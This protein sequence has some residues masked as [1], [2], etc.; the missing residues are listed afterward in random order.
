MQM[1]FVSQVDIP[2]KVIMSH[3]RVSTK[4][5]ISGPRLTS[6]RA[7]VLKARSTASG[8]HLARSTVLSPEFD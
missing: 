2:Y 5:P 3:T 7:F 1:R 4:L 6:C 8:T